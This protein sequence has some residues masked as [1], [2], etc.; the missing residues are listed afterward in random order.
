[1]RGLPSRATEEDILAFFRG[2]VSIASIAINMGD[3]ERHNGEAILHLTSALDG[4][5][6]LRFDRECMG[7]R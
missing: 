6:A 1:M 7:H 4:E 5:R 2:E 3:D